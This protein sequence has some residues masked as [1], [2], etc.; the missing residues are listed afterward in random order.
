MLIRLTD[1]E[2]ALLA[3]FT[4]WNFTNNPRGVPPRDRNAPSGS[5]LYDRSTRC[6]SL[7]YNLYKRDREKEREIEKKREK[8]RETEATV[9]TRG[10]DG[11]RLRELALVGETFSYIGRKKIS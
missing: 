8:E 4:P 9:A 3:T 5:S 2:T 7:R 11:S 6:L 1:R 10:F